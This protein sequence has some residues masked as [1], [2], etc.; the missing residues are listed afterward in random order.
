MTGGAVYM[1]IRY[2]G[3]FEDGAPFAVLIMNALSPLFSGNNRVF[4]SNGRE[5]DTGEGGA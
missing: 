2:F 5:T 3:A 4:S 1:L